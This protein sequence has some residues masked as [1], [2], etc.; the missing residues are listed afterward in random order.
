M[1]KNCKRCRFSTKDKHGLLCEKVH[2]ELGRYRPISNGEG[3][4][5]YLPKLRA[6][7]EHYA[8]DCFNFSLFPNLTIAKYYSDIV[9]EFA[10]LFLIVEYK[11]KIKGK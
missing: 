5:F 3:C 7:W 2:N 10:W 8:T 6:K 11:F 9:V 1:R 4:L